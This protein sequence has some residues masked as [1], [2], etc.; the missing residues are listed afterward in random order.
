MNYD[1]LITLENLFSAWY[2][3]R[4]GKQNRNDV[5]QFERG[6]EDNIFQ[7]HEELI[8]K[9]YKHQGY[10][11]FHVYDPKFRVINKAT[12]RD[13]IVHHLIYN[14]LEPIFQPAFIHQSYSSQTGKGVHIAVNELAAALRQASKNYSTPVWSLKLDIKK[15]FDSIDHEILLQLLCKKV[16]DEN[17]FWLLEEIVQ[18]YTSSQG[19]G[20]GVPIGNLTSQIFANIYLSELDYYVKFNL[21][22]HYYFRYADDFIFL[23]A[24]KA[25]LEKIQRS[26]EQFVRERLHM[27][28][29]PNKIVYRKL[30]Q[31]IDFVGYVLLPHYRVLRTKTKKRMF[32]KIEKKVTEYNQAV[33]DELSLRQTTQAYLG[34]LKHCSGHLL[35]QQVSNEVWVRKELTSSLA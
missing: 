7:L 19:P 34:L 9:T 1:E 24:D 33:C 31:G 14:F 26:V 13:R 10:S 15:F 22:E 12:V 18:G 17:I 25:H 29:H 6:L 32:K 3:F 20:R 16:Q 30:S 8:T 23:H 2:Q 21:R 28:V 5:M 11:T 4:H 27:T 35:H